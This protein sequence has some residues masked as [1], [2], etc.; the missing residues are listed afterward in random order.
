[1]PTSATSAIAA[2]SARS[3]TRSL[4]ERVVEDRPERVDRER[5]RVHL[6]GLSVADLDEEG[7]RALHLE[8][9]A[10]P[11]RGMRLAG[12][13][14]RGG[15]LLQPGPVEAEI[16]RDPLE[17]VVRHPPGVLVSLVCVER[18][19][20][21]P[22]LAL[23]P[24]GQDV[25]QRLLGVLADEREPRETELDLSR[26][27]V[28]LDDVGEAV[29]LVLPADRALEIL[30]LDHRHGG[31]LRAELRVRLRD[32]GE[33]RGGGIARGRAAR[34]VVAAAAAGDDDAHDHEDDRDGPGRGDQQIAVPR[35]RVTGRRL[36]RLGGH[37]ATS[38]PA[39]AG[40]R[41]RTVTGTRTTWSGV[42][43]SALASN[44]TI[45]ARP[46]RPGIASS[47]S[48]VPR[49]PFPAV[50]V[51]KS[52]KTTFPDPS[53]TSNETVA[54]KTLAV[55]DTWIGLVTLSPGRGDS[56]TIWGV[57][58]SDVVDSEPPHPP[59]TSESATRA[60][61]ARLTRRPRARGP[62]GFVPRPART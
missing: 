59:A 20:E 3:L 14:L 25:Q 11:G 5:A 10:F 22:K 38:L 29:R 43:S 56:I 33:Q 49:V 4:C 2:R 55:P 21:L 30:E 44:A 28:L 1:M 61:A 60:G 37:V 7:R 36:T 50:A 62:R 42:P 48:N 32:P 26:P 8:A 9:C 19:R 13:L 16:A 46:E 34:T 41:Q 39:A 18:V 45:V 31:A 58:A 23:L 17:Q 27:H 57:C 15:V 12:D 51:V 52:R 53:R 40:L 35:A 6:I 24:R 54:S 47:L